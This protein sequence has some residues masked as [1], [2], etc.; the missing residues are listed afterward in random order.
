MPDG[1]VEACGV[2]LPHVSLVLGGTWMGPKLVGIVFGGV[3][4]S[5]DMWDPCGDRRD[6][7]CREL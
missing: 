7:P 5:F 4:T 2:G 3:D 6:V 1:S